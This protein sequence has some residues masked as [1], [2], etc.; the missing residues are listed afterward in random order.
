M[1]TIAES[2]AFFN[3]DCSIKGLADMTAYDRMIN[4][5]TKKKQIEDNSKK[6]DK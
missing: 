3:E 2:V 1:K 4:D 6:I 5:Y